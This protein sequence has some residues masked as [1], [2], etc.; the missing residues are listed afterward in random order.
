MTKTLIGLV[1]AVLVVALTGCGGHS[2]SQKELAVC[3]SIHE[4]P[5]LFDEVLIAHHP[6]IDYPERT[7]TPVRLV[8]SKLGKPDE[9]IPISNVLFAWWR[10]G[11]TAYLIATLAADR[12]GH[13]YIA[14]VSCDWSFT[15]K[16]ARA[17]L[18]NAGR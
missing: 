2:H 17:L 8:T 16:R 7:L 4:N 13:E 14:A 15:Q 9:T 3:R 12:P 10:Y 6:A 18:K 11:N 5:V 1:V